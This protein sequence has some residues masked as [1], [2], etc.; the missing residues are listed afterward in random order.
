[1]LPPYKQ[2]RMR[3]QS[4]LLPLVVVVVIG[5]VLIA[6]FKSRPSRPDF[7][8]NAHPKHKTGASGQQMEELIM[9]AGHAVMTGTDQ[10]LVDSEESWFLENLQHGQLSTYIRHIEKGVELA[11]ANPL[12]VLIYSGGQTRG[13][14]GPRSEGMSY[15]VASQVKGWWGHPEVKERTLAEEFAR[16][17]FENLMFSMCRFHE[18]YGVYPKRLTVVSYSY[19]KQRFDALHRE[20]I[21]FPESHFKYVGVDPEVNPYN[22]QRNIDKYVDVLP[23]A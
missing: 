22:D 16:D 11:A 12:S 5:V 1:M 9:V 6:T 7:V 3:G 14:A 23:N 10:T 21:Q 17:S 13:V 2:K 19:K 15:W 18:A 8:D 20:A 4:R